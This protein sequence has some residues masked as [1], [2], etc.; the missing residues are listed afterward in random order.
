M[1]SGNELRIRFAKP[2]DLGRCAEFDASV[3]R[4]RL[5]RKLDAGE[6]LVAEA[7]GDM[8]G[9]LRLEYLWLKLPFIGLIHVDAS[10]RRA[11]VGRAMLTFLEDFLRGRGDGVLFSSSMADATLAQGWHRRMGFEECGFLAGVNEGAIGEV[12]YR[13]ALE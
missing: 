12:F 10:R 7:A 2:N 6:V 3:P 11:G 5:A 1:T 4:E 8:V 9:Y 13:K